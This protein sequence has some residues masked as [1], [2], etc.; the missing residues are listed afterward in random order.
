MNK[1]KR[2]FLK[3]QQLKI[4]IVLKNKIN[5]KF[6]IWKL[7]K[8]KNRHQK[9]VQKNIMKKKKEEERNRNSERHE[10]EK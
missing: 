10:K 2:K 7:H 9:N 3:A 1:V 4:V 5:K 8:M 6:K